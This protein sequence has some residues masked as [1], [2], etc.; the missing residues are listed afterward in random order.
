ME[1]IRPEAVLADAREHLLRQF[2][3]P[4]R[5]RDRA[6]KRLVRPLPV[7]EIVDGLA[8]QQR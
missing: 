1:I 4:D 3:V 6:V 2:L 7:T 5:G 8:N